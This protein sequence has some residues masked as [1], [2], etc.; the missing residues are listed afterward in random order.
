MKKTEIRTAC[1]ITND[2][3]TSALLFLVAHNLIKV[4]KDNGAI[5]YYS[6]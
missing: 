5:D 3:A 6:K 4:N 2:Q 1:G